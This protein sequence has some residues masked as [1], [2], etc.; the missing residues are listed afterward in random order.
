MPDTVTPYL[1]Y[2]DAD[3]AI[4]W[5]RT[6]FG[7]RERLRYAGEDGRVSHAE[8]ETG[9]ESVMVGAPG[10]DYQSPSRSGH[11]H[12]YVHVYVDDVD[13]HYA[14]AKKA[15]ATI[16][17][18]PEDQPYGDRRYHAADLEGHQWFFAQHLREVTPEEWGA[19]PA[20]PS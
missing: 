10:G 3:A 2:E 6:A 14:R 17:S 11:V 4:D 8:L 16:V 1:A 13:A 20:Q 5:L 19:V 15:G 7:F 9:G 12:V 18:E